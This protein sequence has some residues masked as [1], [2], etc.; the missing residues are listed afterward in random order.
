MTVLEDTDA[1]GAIVEARVAPG[2]VPAG[3]DLLPGP[4]ALGTALHSALAE[5]GTA[6]QTHAA[7]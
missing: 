4:D 1:L 6:R 3:D 5:L 7:A 2:A